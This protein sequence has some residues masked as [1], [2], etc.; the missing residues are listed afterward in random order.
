MVKLADTLTDQLCYWGLH[1]SAVI[2][3]ESLQESKEGGKTTPYS[4]PPCRS[5]TIGATRRW[6]CGD[7]ERL[8]APRRFERM[9]YKQK[10]A[11]QAFCYVV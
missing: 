6:F 8:C 7:F 2:G 11:V 5:K 3:L 9:H 1:D 4:I 10:G